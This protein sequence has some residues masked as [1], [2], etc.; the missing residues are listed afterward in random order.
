M[1]EGGREGRREG[2]RERG[3]EVGRE[4]GRKG[5]VGAFVCTCAQCV[6][7]KRKIIQH[8]HLAMHVH[9]C[10]PVWKQIQVVCCWGEAMPTSE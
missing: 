5:W 7:G 6:Y 3:R 2:G 1:R 4:R 8:K 10:S 9:T